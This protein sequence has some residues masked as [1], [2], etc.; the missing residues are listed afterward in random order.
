MRIIY[1]VLKE[2]ALLLI[3]LWLHM[4]TGS[5]APSSRRTTTAS[6]RCPTR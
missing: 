1:L 6:G 5:V 3:F 2:P 4:F